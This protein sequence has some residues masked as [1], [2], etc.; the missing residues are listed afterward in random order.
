[1]DENIVKD[2]LVSVCCANEIILSSGLIKV[3]YQS[4]I[5]GNFQFDVG[6]GR[7]LLSIARMYMVDNKF[8]YFKTFNPPPPTRQPLKVELG[9]LMI[10]P[11]TRFEEN[12]F[13]VSLQN[14]K[15]IKVLPLCRSTHTSNPIELHQFFKFLLEHAINLEKL[16][17]VPDHKDCN[18]CSSNTTNLMKYLFAF[19]TSAIISLG[20]VS[21]N[22]FYKLFETLE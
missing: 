11:D 20:P 18:N 12:I 4:Q 2:H 15:N 6:K 21:H 17:I 3:S 5:L 7:T 10:F 16:V 19:P 8:L 14:L 1:M 22:V 9:N 13:K